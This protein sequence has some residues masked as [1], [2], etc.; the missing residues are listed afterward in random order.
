M[1]IR[2]HEYVVYIYEFIYIESLCIYIIHAY[3]IYYIVY[4][5]YIYLNLISLV[6][7]KPNRELAIRMPE[8]F[9]Q[10]DVNIAGNYNTTESRVANYGN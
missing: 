1:H 7:R 9:E 6:G 4:V 10:V 8:I 2:I 5:M 3:C